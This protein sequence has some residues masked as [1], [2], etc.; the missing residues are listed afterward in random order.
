MES[1]LAVVKAELECPREQLPSPRTLS[2]G[3]S[4]RGCQLPEAV[5]SATVLVLVARTRPL[6]FC[7]AADALGYLTV[8]QAAGYRIKIAPFVESIL[9]T[10]A[11]SGDRFFHVHC[12]S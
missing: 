5:H 2:T 9:V 12:F 8:G 6:L 7:A 1:A 11:W 3:N 4:D 10:L